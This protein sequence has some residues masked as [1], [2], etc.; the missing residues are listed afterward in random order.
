MLI[1]PD[2]YCAAAFFPNDLERAL[3]RYTG[4]MASLSTK[5]LEA[6]VTT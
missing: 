3:D 6:V 1:R 2:R 5:G 4:M